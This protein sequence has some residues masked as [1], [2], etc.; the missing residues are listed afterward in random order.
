[1]NPWFS[2]AVLLLAVVGMAIVRAPQFGF[3]RR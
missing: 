1:M 2:K 3:E